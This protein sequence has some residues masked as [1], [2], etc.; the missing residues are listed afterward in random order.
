MP[1]DTV[2]I[3]S[4]YLL[5][6][7]VLSCSGGGIVKGGLMKDSKEIREAMLRIGDWQAGMIDAGLRVVD[8]WARARRGRRAV[9][10]LSSSLLSGPAKNG[11]PYF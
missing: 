11:G 3:N 1:T 6:C 4:L 7:P 8:R 2:S 9:P 5:S 10:A